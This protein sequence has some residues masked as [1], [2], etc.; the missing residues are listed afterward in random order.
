MHR[1]EQQTMAQ[2]KLRHWS[3]PPAGSFMSLCS[4]RTVP[5]S[6]QLKTSIRCKSEK[7][8]RE[9]LQPNNFGCK[10]KEKAHWSS[11][12]KSAE[13]CTTGDQVRISAVKKMADDE[14]IMLFCTDDNWLPTKKKEKVYTVRQTQVACFCPC[15][16]AVI[17]VIA[18]GVRTRC[19]CVFIQTSTTSQK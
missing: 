4:T 18:A 15:T 19:V 6:V 10:R 13:I 17:A 5:S 3:P 16:N 2:A 12:W 7:V 8:E 9:R 1:E 14:W 11:R